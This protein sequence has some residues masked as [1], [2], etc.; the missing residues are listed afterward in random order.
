MAFRIQ[1]HE[2]F[3][4]EKLTVGLK[5]DGSFIQGKLRGFLVIRV[6]W[7]LL[8]GECM[9]RMYIPVE[10]RKMQICSFGWV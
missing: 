1:I 5:K 9:I 4:P 10:F 6:G 2:A 8:V 7:S 3:S